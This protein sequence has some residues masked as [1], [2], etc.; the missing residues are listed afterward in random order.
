MKIATA[1]IIK[2]LD[3]RTIQEHGI[4]GEKLMERAGEGVYRS[5]IKRFSA[6]AA[7]GVA[8]F[9]GKGNNGGDGFVVARYLARDGVPVTM[10]LLG[11]HDEVKGDARVNLDRLTRMNVPFTEVTSAR[12]VKKIAGTITGHGLIVDAIFGTG[13]DNE[14]TGVYGEVIETINSCGKPVVAVDI[15][16]GL[17]ADTGKP[18]GCAVKADLTV[19][20]GLAKIGQVIHPGSDYTGVLNV[21]DIGFPQEL[22]SS[23]PI[24]YTLDDDG[25]F[26][27][28]FPRRKRDSHKGTYGHVLIIAG[29]VGKTGAAALCA[30]AAVRSGAGLV[31]VGVPKSI[32]PVIAA[33]LDEAMP[34]PLPET[35]AGTLSTRA[36][37][38]ISA[39]LE[40]KGALAVGPGLSTH[41][42]TRKAL[43]SLVEKVTIP[44]VIDADG[45]NNLSGA[46]KLLKKARAPRILTPH[47]G[48]MARLIG[49]TVKKIQEDRIATA[50]DFAVTY[51]VVL[52]L[53]GA[54]T[55]IADPRGHVYIN[56]TG[57]PGM[58]SGG[59]GDVLTGMIGSFLAQGF[60]PVDA[61]RAGVF[62]HGWAGDRVSDDQG[63]AGMAASDLLEKI[64]LGIRRFTR[65]GE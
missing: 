9:C 32:Y 15:P 18:L 55:V 33:K 4:P 35:T 56:S 31:T 58:A 42:E 65:S 38:R 28:F 7:Q 34:E 53:K 23:A 51:S 16:S 20:M 12:E 63:E 47:P 13:L 19:T 5:I 1:D 48:E 40:G 57:N 29:S 2:E 61:S 44:M 39:L 27:G 60:S 24:P 62:L 22:V 49:S 8:I 37:K 41:A 64:P 3:R 17:S 46:L 6:E 25:E 21:V 11:S 43:L 26:T 36:G 54:R 10:F 45:L 52:V 14:V 50:R 59:M 30:R